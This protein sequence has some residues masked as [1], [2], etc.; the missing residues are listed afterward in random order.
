[1]SNAAIAKIH[2]AKKELALDN[3]TYRSILKRVTGSVSSK[4][5]TAKQHADVLA[6][7]NR[8]GWKVKTAPSSRYRKAH[9]NPLIRKVWAMGKE[10]DRRSYWD[11]PWKKATVA[12]VRKETGVDD[13]D[14][15]DNVQASKVVEALKAISR[16]L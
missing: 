15:L 5:M 13:P 8:L 12:F 10:L 11:L 1:M 14:W 4:G 9:P 16:R 2:I 7:F 3:E 6:E